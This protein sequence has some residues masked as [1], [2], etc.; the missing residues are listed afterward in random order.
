VPFGLI[1]NKAGIG[2]QEMYKFRQEN[3]IDLLAEIPFRRDLAAVYATGE[4]W[5][6]RFPEM[7]E[8]FAGVLSKVMLSGRTA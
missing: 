6:D 4:I 2:N 3:H 8:S 5:V 7:R 1:I